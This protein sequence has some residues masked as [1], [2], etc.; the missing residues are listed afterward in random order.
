MKMIVVLLLVNA[1]RSIPWAC[2]RSSCRCKAGVS[3]FVEVVGW[4]I[5]THRCG[6]QLVLIHS[7]SRLLS[8]WSCYVTIVHVQ[9]WPRTHFVLEYKEVRWLVGWTS[10]VCVTSGYLFFWM[11]AKKLI[12]DLFRILTST[13]VS[14]RSLWS[15][16]HV[17]W[18]YH[19]VSVVICVL[20]NPPYCLILFE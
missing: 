19:S 7:S 11:K 6:N 3:V 20:S 16:L 18:E 15:R 5:R 12:L 2:I 8:L 9:T 10:H 1:S 4:C 17:C 13:S 14:I